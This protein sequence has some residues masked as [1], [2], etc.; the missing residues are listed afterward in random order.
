MSILGLF[1]KIG[2]C[3][4]RWL[5]VIA[6]HR[7]EKGLGIVWDVLAT[8]KSKP[9]FDLVLNQEVKCDSWDLQAKDFE[10]QDYIEIDGRK[11]WLFGFKR[12]DWYMCR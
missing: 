3:R 10:T 9:G 6:K 7:S 8:I 2:F 4:E 1:G 5:V 11:I 12:G